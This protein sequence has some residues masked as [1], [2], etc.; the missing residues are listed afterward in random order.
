MVKNYLLIALRSIRKNFAYS[1]INIFGLGLGLTICILIV[2]WIQHELSFDRFH[3][4][5]GIIYRTSLE[6]SFGGQTSKTSVSP[7]ALLPVLSRNFSEIKSGVRLYNPASFS[8][9][10][11]SVDNNKFQES[12]FYFADSSFFSVFSFP[13][14]KGTASSVLNAP[15][16]IVFTES[17]AKK[18]FGETDPIGKVVRVNDTREYIVTGV[19]KDLPDNSTLQAD[20]IASFSTLPQSKEEQWWSANYETFF[21]L[22]SQADV[23]ALAS[24]TNAL[25]KEALANELTNAND[26]VVY[27]WIPLTD[28][29]LYSEMNESVP[30][31]SIQYVYIFS[32]VALI[33]LLLAAINYINLTTARAMDRAKEVGIRK[34]VG[35]ER[36]QLIFQHLS[37]SFLVTLFAFIVAMLFVQLLLP[38]FNSITGKELNRDFFTTPLFMGVSSLSVVALTFL[39]GAYPALAITSFRPVS[40]LKGNFKTSAKGLWLRKSLV[41]AQFCISVILMVGTVTISKQLDFMQNKKLGYEKESILLLPLDGKTETAYDQLKTEFLR[42]GKVASV[43]RATESPTNIRGGYSISLE[44]SSSEKGIIVTA[45]AIDPEFIPTLGMELVAGRN[46][47]ETDMQIYKTDTTYGFIVNESTLHELGLQPE[48]A[49]GQKANVNGRKGEIIGVVKDFHFTSLHEPIAPFI[50]FNEEGQYNYIFVKLQAGSLQD[51]LGSLKDVYAQ[52]V[53][54]RPFEYEF[55]DQQYE[56]LYTSEQR[57]STLFSVFAGLAMIIACLGLFGLVSFSASQR[58]KEIG[59]R[60][61]LGATAS[62][63]V[64]LITTEYTRLI[65]LAIA[66]AI[67]ISVWINNLLLD[68]FAY[69]TTVGPVYLISIAFASLVVALGTAS[70]Q[71]IKAS[72]INPSESMRSE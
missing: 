45:S 13:L 19:M 15:N 43:T 27:N 22:D 44:G 8:P 36:S 41:V 46:Y 54:H 29:H 31:G 23:I 49:I 70:F 42:T 1:L 39:A 7:T 21:V 64:L 38:F 4:P 10:V 28:I 67:P 2:I 33:I 32:G 18:Y 58:T 66:L 48:N 71:A 63:I 6:Y 12:S 72:L 35:A 50:F 57:L 52:V 24:K 53:P 14:V 51:A 56:A 60:K 40:I 17:S 30:V 61:V 59:I 47:T 11:V 69:K 9:F 3:Q 5:N 26:Y 34:T 20:F 25:V 37:E 65:L 68:G 62:S 16:T 55:L